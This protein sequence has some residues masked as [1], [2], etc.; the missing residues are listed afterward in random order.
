MVK[1]YLHNIVKQFKSYKEVADKTIT[2][3]EEQD[4]HW[5]YN[6]ESNSIA[7]IMI[8]VSENMLSRW[9]DFFI[10]DGEKEW[11]NRDQEF[12]PQKLNKQELID[13]WENGWNCLFNAL[14]S[15]N[16]SNFDQPIYIRNKQH[17][18]IESITR[19]IAHYP[20]HIGQIAYIG[21]MILNNKWQ[22]ASIAKGKSKEF[23]QAQF[24]LNKKGT[25]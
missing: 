19:Q 7:S 13:K 24:E 5:K 8:H 3:L 18:L 9:T 10:S 1:E 4:L 15:L 6:E 2:Q 21:K 12:E 14:N 17:K 11:R 25:L 22:T 16:E 23:I 20:Y